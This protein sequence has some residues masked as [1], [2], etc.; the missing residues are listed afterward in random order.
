ME[1]LLEVSDLP[2]PVAWLDVREGV[3][4]SVL[5]AER[6]YSRL[7][8]RW[9][10]RTSP[11]VAG[12]HVGPELSFNALARPGCAIRRARLNTGAS[13]V[14][15][16]LGPTESEHPL[17]AIV[18]WDLAGREVA[19]REFDRTHGWDA[20]WF[21]DQLVLGVHDGAW[22]EAHGAKVE[23]WNADLDR[24][25]DRLLVN[26]AGFD[27]VVEG[28]VVAACGNDLHLWWP[29]TERAPFSLHE[30]SAAPPGEMGNGVLSP[31]GKLAAVVHDLWRPGEPQAL[32][33]RVD[34]PG[35][36]PVTIS[37]GTAHQVANLAFN[38]DGSLIAASLTE[39][40]D[41]RVYSARD[42]SVVGET[43]M[44]KHG[45]LAWLDTETLLVG[46]PTLTAWRVR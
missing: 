20:A 17:A 3:V 44:P 37:D 6:D 10:W 30:S 24:P 16:V 40:P 29:G 31:D 1:K 33:I 7:D 23:I 41:V 43:Q 9:A 38:S 25:V 28:S 26:D 21:G 15:A 19:R 5:Q 46:G 36:E 34:E 4:L 2:G 8:G 18:V 35:A 22:T 39:R 13:R 12:L 32:I 42:G 27:V 45:A 11:G 14:V